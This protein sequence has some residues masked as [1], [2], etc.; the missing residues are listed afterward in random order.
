M[1]SV[2]T[3]CRAIRHREM[4]FSYLMPSNY[5]GDVMA[6]C[7][8]LCNNNDDGRG[9]VCH[10]LFLLTIHKTTSLP[11]CLSLVFTSTQ[12]SYLAHPRPRRSCQFHLASPTADPVTE[13]SKV[14]FHIHRP[15][16]PPSSRIVAYNI[17]CQSIRI[18]LSTRRK[19]T[20]PGQ[21]ISEGR[22]NIIHILH[23]VFPQILLG[24]TAHFSASM[25]GNASRLVVELG[26]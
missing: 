17:T 19:Q 14:A 10:C 2:F 20:R 11:L 16:L 3:F 22:S 8:K 1:T 23:N 12:P 21:S 26:M 15:H 25:A 18:R 7:S 9:W 4:H 24:I 6:T 5:D 13:H